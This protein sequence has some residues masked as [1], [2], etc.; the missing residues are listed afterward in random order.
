[1]P[2]EK[3]MI[4]YAI[5]TYFFKIFFLYDIMSFINNYYIYYLRIILHF[6]YCKFIIANYFMPS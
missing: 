2:K 1:M 4:H 5:M 3:R 6:K